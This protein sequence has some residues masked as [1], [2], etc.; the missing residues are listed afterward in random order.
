MKKV[1]FICYANACRSQI[2][3]AISNRIGGNLLEAYSAGINP[4]GRICVEV[5]EL[6]KEKGFDI[7]NQYSKGIY[8]IPLEE[9]DFVITMGCCTANEICPVAFAGKKLDWEIPDPFGM[10][11]ITVEEVFDLIYEK[12]EEF[13]KEYFLKDS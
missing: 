12:I 4:L 6:M 1:V 10:D 2:A 5:E 13:I 9:M 11:R 7:S 8:E 3:E